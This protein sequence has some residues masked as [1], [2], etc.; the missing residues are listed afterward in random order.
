MTNCMDIRQDNV[1][2]LI[3]IFR[4]GYRDI[5]IYDLLVQNLTLEEGEKFI[6]QIIDAATHYYTPEKLES[7][8]Q[9]LHR[10]VER[11]RLNNCD[12]FYNDLIQLYFSNDDCKGSIQLSLLIAN[13]GYETKFLYENLKGDARIQIECCC[14]LQKKEFTDALRLAYNLIQN[15]Y[16]PRLLEFV[17]NNIELNVENCKDMNKIIDY[18]IEHKDFHK[19]YLAINMYVK[20]LFDNKNMDIAQKICNNFDEDF[21]APFTKADLYVSE[22][23]DEKLYKFLSEDLDNITTFFPTCHWLFKAAVRLNKTEE[24]E[25]I[26]SA[27]CEDKKYL[28]QLLDSL[29]EY[30]NKISNRPYRYLKE[31]EC[32]EKL[33]TLFC[34]N[35]NYYVGFQTAI[36][37]FIVNN[38]NI[39]NNV[40][41]HIGI[42]NSVD[43]EQLIG[44]MEILDIDYKITNIAKEYQT[45]ELKVNYGI[46][47]HYTLD[48]SAYYRIFMIDRM[49]R[50]KDIN[51]ILYLDSDILILSSLYELAVMDMKESLYA[52]L[53]DQDATAVVESK[54]V[55]QI[56]KYFNSGVLLINAKSD[57]V[58]SQ[59][60][61]AIANT[62]KQENLIMHDQCA[63]NIAFNNNFGMLKDKYNFLVHHQNLNFEDAD[64]TVLHLSGRIKPWQEDY[65]Q[66][67]F[68]SQL[69]HSYYNMVKLWKNK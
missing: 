43:K 25:E 4:G 61:N 55:N 34:I 6:K 28:S 50:D 27:K 52:Y 63:L 41:F 14:A 37:S 66:N 30:N 2:F 67:E 5:E 54:L 3:R 10:Y 53:E 13:T 62:N 48:K 42:D 49:L 8:I 23:N 44:F 21:I 57:S 51:R 20:R 19:Y 31:I 58:R 29:K 11:F 17:S 7:A 56:S 22:N 33:H 1:D 60:K 35:K 18:I 65:H 64:I 69:W 40:V 46:K 38:V 32:K 26:V 24:L 16:Y 39:I 9:L 45:E 68:I 15:E 59:I 36:I 47:T 12:V